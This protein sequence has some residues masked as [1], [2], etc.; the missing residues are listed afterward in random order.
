MYDD[1]EGADKTAQADAVHAVREAPESNVPPQFPDQDTVTAD[2]QK[3]QE[4][5][6]AEN[7]PAGTNLG[8]PIAASDPSDVLTYSL[9][10]T[11]RTSAL[12]SINRAT[13]Q[14]STKAKLD[15]EDATQV[16]VDHVLDVTVTATDPFGA[17]DSSMVAI[18]VTDVNEAPT[19]TAVTT[20]IDR[21][22]TDQE[23]GPWPTYTATD[24]DAADMDDDLE[25]S[26]AGAD[27]SKF[28]I[29]ESGATG[30]LV[31]KAAPAPLPDYESPGDSNRN[32]VYEVTVVVTDS[33]GNSDEQDVTVKVTNVEE[34]GTVT[35]FPLQPQVD[36]PVTATL[37]DP[38]NVTV[39]SVSWQWYRGDSAEDASECADADSD[40]CFIKGATSATYTP[41]ADDTGK[42]L[43]AVA[44]Y[45]DGFGE[46]VATGTLENNILVLADPRNKAPVFPDRDSR[47]DGRQTD[48]KRTVAEDLDAP[49]NI[50]DPVIAMDSAGEILTYSLGGADA[51]SFTIDAATG[52]LTAKAALDKETKDTYTVTV[53]AADPLN[54]R[55]T[56]TV[57]I[58]VTNVDEMPELEGP[59]SVKYPENG[60][61][62]VAT[63]TAVDPEGKSIVWSLADWRRRCCL[64][65]HRWG[66]AFRESP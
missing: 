3:D 4:R 39:S 29:N 49:R 20:S 60:T 55:S 17:S 18:M 25:W 6:V 30:A 53:T 54:A 27:S 61:G 40:D 22:E 52:Q 23:L 11:D 19:L 16:G 26:L 62:Q 42:T 50:G 15:Y 65:H 12:F 9:S 37:A 57:T 46:D 13:G 28:S 21:A 34:P 63:F 31:F 24:A 33:K 8:A 56:I 59:A 2:I 36:V 51:A 48:Q 32:N 47:T 7:T 43:T 64:H 45:T 14:L 41:V 66:T 10:G 38:D 5:E 44:T 1:G 58:K 35:L